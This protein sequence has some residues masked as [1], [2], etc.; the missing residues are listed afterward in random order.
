MPLH[1]T[2]YYIA[3]VIEEDCIGCGT[4]VDICPMKA[5]ELEDAVSQIDK[6]RCI[7]CGLCAHHCPEDAIKLTH[8][9]LRDVFVLPPKL[10]QN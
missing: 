8:T 2:T 4:C 10:K 1:T 5:I 9:G 3:D 6:S 7:G